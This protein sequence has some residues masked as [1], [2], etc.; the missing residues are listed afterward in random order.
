MSKIEI[1]LAKKDLKKYRDLI[2]TLK[3]LH[4]DILDEALP[5]P[6]PE[7][8]TKQINIEGILDVI[9]LSEVCVEALESHID[10]LE[11]E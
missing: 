4:K 2:Q 9:N 7:D 5:V 10:D 11:N 6:M 3:V 8:R 1:Q